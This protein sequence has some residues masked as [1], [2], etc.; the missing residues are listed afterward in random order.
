MRFGIKTID[1]FD[2]QGKTVLLRVDINQ[3]V[4]KSRGTLKDITR[5][6]ACLPTI[7]ELS[8]K[9]AK[10]VI[11]AH[12]GGDLEY[13]NYYTTE[14]HAKV[15]SE[16][17]GKNV[18][19]IDDVVGPAARNRIKNLL[20]GQILMLDN[21]RFL[22]EEMTL[23]ETKLNLSPEEQSRTE[24]V[25]KLAPLADIYVCDA[26]AAAH[27]AQPSLVGF[28]QC[29]PSAMGRLFEEEYC[30]ISG[31][32]EEPKRPCVFILGG[33]KIQDAFL[34][35]ST[36]LKSGVADTILTGGLVSQIM[37]LASN[38]DLGRQSAAYIVKNNLSA[39]IEDARK[40]LAN[41]HDKII[42]PIDVAITEN[43]RHEI[44]V[45][46]L[47]TD[48]LVVD[49]GEETVKKYTDLITQA[50]TIFINGPMG[51]FE[52]ADSDYGT[53]AIW[54]AVAHANAYSVVGGGDSIAATNQ[55]GLENSF[56]YL[57]TGG[58]AL[59]RF[60][61]GEELPVVKALREAAIRFGN[62]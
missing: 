57:C 17:L 29:L 11:L 43:G 44:D 8:E 4:D 20:D 32:M 16:L 42:V 38:V 61:S 21:V 39:Y 40:L 5:I 28:Q 62:E 37:F 23:F 26:F 6:K 59:V 19:F 22:A 10:V 41:Y 25:K 15:M 36:V 24:V 48:S 47:P 9:K 54:E 50:G 18:H 46:D 1:D 31:V 56:S 52:Q 60:L 58:G 12:Q 55:Y 13:Q 2:M 3:P 51:V 27:R 49:I 35:M 34:M 30:V 53:K 14:P 45:T 7:R 33:A